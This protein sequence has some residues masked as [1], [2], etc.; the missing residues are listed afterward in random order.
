MSSKGNL[1]PLAA[2]KPRPCLCRRY[3]FIW[4]PFASEWA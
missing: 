1:R 3:V 2:L 4:L